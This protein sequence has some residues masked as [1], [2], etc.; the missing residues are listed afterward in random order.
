[1]MTI[2]FRARRRPSRGECLF[3]ARE[4]NLFARTTKAA[5]AARKDLERADQVVRGEVGPKDIGEI[6]LGVRRFDEQEVA[7][8]LLAARA[9]EQIDVGEI[10]RSEVLS[11]GADLDVL[12]EEQT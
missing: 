5:F 7:Q 9:N 6:Q 11:Q 4:P 3:H 10:A 12:G 2:A 8:A 1:M